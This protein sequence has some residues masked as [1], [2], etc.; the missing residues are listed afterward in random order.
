MSDTTRAPYTGSKEADKEVA[1]WPIGES[2]KPDAQVKG[3]SINHPAPQRDICGSS[4][5]EVA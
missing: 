2:C 1:A 4:S 5:E 3:A